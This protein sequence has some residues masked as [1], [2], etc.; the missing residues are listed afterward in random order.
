M[1]KS[2]KSTLTTE[3]KGSQSGHTD[4]PTPQRRVISQVSIAA[5]GSKPLVDPKQKRI[6]HHKQAIKPTCF[7]SPEK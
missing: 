2:A 1:S 5:P 4:Q 6:D 3:C 7:P